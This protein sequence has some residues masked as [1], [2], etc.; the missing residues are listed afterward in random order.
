MEDKHGYI[1]DICY[2]NFYNRLNHYKEINE[3]EPSNDL[4]GRES[5]LEY[6][7]RIYLEELNIPYK[8]QFR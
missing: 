3:L 1:F 5:R 6:K 7:V 8:Q 2:N 4:K